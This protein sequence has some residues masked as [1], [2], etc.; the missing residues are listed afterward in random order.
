MKKVQ[1]IIDKGNQK[2]KGQDQTDEKSKKF[3]GARRN[4]QVT[5]ANNSVLETSSQDSA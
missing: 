5:S 4:Q 2:L 3:P 1:N